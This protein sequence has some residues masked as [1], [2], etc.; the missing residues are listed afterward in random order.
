[1]TVVEWPN[2]ISPGLWPFRLAAPE[3]WSAVEPTEGLIAFLGPPVDGFRANLVLFGRRLPEDLTLGEVA[4]LALLDGGPQRVVD[5]GID[6]P[7]AAGGLPVAVRS[8]G[9]TVD[10]REVRQIAVVTE[11]P[12]YS[13]TGLRSVYTMLGTCLAGRADPDE[14]TLTSVM[15]SFEL[16]R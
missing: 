3:Q 13:P 1:M 8:S 15:A 12:D 5:P 10:G 7:G 11:A 9:T 14:S 6:R 4:E 2:A 16:I